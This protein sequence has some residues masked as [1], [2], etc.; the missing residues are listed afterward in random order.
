[1]VEAIHQALVAADG[2][3][4]A[5][6]SRHPRSFGSGRRPPRRDLVGPEQYVTAGS[7]TKKAESTSHKTTPRIKWGASQHACIPRGRTSERSS[8]IYDNTYTRP[9]LRSGYVSASVLA[10]VPSATRVCVCASTAVSE[11]SLPTTKMSAYV[12]S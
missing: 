1:M 4:R 8:G 9:P 6:G 5:D 10:E 11:M 12:R 7:R 2:S 3:G